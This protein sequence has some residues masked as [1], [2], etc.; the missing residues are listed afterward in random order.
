MRR[1]HL[2]LRPVTGVR[3]QDGGV[4]AP[5]RS[6]VLTLRP[7]NR[8]PSG[9]RFFRMAAYAFPAHSTSRPAGGMVVTIPV[10]CPHCESEYQLSPDLVGKSMR[11]PNPDCREVFEVRAAGRPIEPVPEVEAPPTEMISV[12]AEAP[13]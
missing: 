4:S 7:K 9:R 1:H 8:F 12:V 11:C 6:C 13:A 2:R 5:L 10:Q 3:A